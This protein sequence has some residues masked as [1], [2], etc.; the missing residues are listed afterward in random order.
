MQ[1]SHLFLFFLLLLFCVSESNAELRT[2]LQRAWDYLRGNQP[3]PLLMKNE[4]EEEPVLDTFGAYDLGGWDYPDQDF[5]YE[6][7]EEERKQEL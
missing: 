4:G 5:Y 1:R 7:G 6:E 3:P 2:F